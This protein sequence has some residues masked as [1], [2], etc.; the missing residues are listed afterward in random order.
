MTDIDTA[1]AEAELGIEIE[2]FLDTNLG[3]YL[4]GC[5]EQDEKDAIEELLSFDPYK[6][7]SLGELQTA[8]AHIQEKVILARKV[9]GYLSDAIINAGQ[10]EHIIETYED[11]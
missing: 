4:M 5:K 2:N 8:F 6:Y 1:V 10:A 7:T 11:S 3:K 9:H